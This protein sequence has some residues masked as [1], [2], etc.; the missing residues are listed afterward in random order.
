MR[1]HLKNYGAVPR[2]QYSEAIHHAVS[3]RLRF[4]QYLAETG[5]DML[6]T[7]SAP[8]EAPA[9]IERTGSSLFN[10]NW[11]LL[12]LPCITLPAGRGPHQLPLGMQ[13]VADYDDDERLLLYA[14]WVRNALL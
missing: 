10:R 12:G 11:T 4:S 13:L 3:C 1:E 9:G 2:A 7:P 5:V 8:D 6:L 14:E